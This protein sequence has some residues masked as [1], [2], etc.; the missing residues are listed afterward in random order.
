RQIDEIF[1][2]DRAG[3]VGERELGRRDHRGRQLGWL[4]E[5]LGRRR[6]RTRPRQRRYRTGAA[7]RDAR[8]L[9]RRLQRHVR[10]RERDRRA[11]LRGVLIVEGLEVRL[12]DPL[13]QLALRRHLVVEQIAHERAELIGRDRRVDVDER[14]LDRVAELG[15]RLVA[16]LGLGPQRGRDEVVVRREALV[17]LARQLVLALGDLLRERAIVRFGTG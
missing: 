7:R 17:D 6:R 14:L 9:G 13:V 16:I 4:L 15:G 10:E 1:G 8:R 11:D 5:D 12:R 3:A 2:L